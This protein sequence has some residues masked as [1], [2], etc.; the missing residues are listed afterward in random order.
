MS[1]H[2]ILIVLWAA[3]GSSLSGRAALAV[4]FDSEPACQAAAA[5]IRR[6]SDAGAA[7][8]A[9]LVC[10]AKGEEKRNDRP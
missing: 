2:Y 8:V 10:A 6:Q 3:Y 4:E 9:T 1:V 7:N 5:A